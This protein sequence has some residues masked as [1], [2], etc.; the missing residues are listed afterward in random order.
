V[1][2]SVLE[3]SVLERSVL[4]RSVLEW[5]VLERPVLEWIG[6]GGQLLVIRSRQ[7]AASSLCEMPSTRALS[8]S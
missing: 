2:W 3:R 7:R 8:R 4:E 1:E 5:L 6:M